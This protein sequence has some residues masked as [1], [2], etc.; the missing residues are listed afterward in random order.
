MRDACS[1]AKS[2]QNGCA[3]EPSRLSADELSSV[4]LW[5]L[6]PSPSARIKPHLTVTGQRTLPGSSYLQTCIGGVSANLV[7]RCA[8]SALSTCTGSRREAFHAGVIQARV[9]IA[10]KETA[11]SPNTNGSSGLHGN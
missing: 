10:N 2:E 3:S 8:H 5:L 7:T 11:T 6:E 9:A 1:R 4:A